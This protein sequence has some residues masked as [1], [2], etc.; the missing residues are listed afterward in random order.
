MDISA[1]G[2]FVVFASSADGL[3]A[4][5]EDRRDENIFDKDRQTGALTDVTAGANGSSSAPSISDDG[6]KVAF[7]TH[8]TNLVAGD[9]T[10]DS[11]VVVKDLAASTTTLLS[12]PANGGC[13]YDCGSP[14]V[15]GD[16]TRVAFATLDK[17]VAAATNTELDVYVRP[18]TGGT[19]VHETLA[20]NLSNGVADASAVL[21]RTV[22]TGAQ[23]VV[24][25]T[26]IADPG[27]ISDDGPKS[28]GLCGDGACVAFIARG[29]DLLPDVSPDYAQE[30]LRVLR[31]G[32]G[33]PQ[34]GPTTPATPP[35]TVVPQDGGPLIPAARD[36]RRAPHHRRGALPDPLPRQ[37]QE[38]GQD[39]EGGEAGGPP[40]RRCASRSTPLRP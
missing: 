2:R 26:A 4:A 34:S 27:A 39:G 8:A 9:T 17:L 29:V 18:V 22:A 24:G 38:D 15:S 10:P 32:C 1:G 36:V 30:Y 25:V 3:V 7:D 20:T 6:T 12:G 13:S 37:R 23:Q 28:A 11:D 16:G 33:T 5:A 19:P 35:S 14:Q 40:A 31:G 21:V